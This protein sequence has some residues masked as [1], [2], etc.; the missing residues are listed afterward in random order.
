MNIVA[1]LRD[2]LSIALG[3]WMVS[4]FESNG[5]ILVDKKTYEALPTVI[6]ERLNPGLVERRAHCLKYD[7]KNS[8]NMANAA[9]AYDNLL[10]TQASYILECLP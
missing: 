10:K 8:P 2:K 6:S 9:I 5:I 1:L 7:A 3:R 4:Y